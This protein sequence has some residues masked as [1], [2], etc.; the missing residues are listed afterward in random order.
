MPKFN[1]AAN[2]FYILNVAQICMY[3]YMK[4]F[5]NLKE[6]SVLLQNAELLPTGF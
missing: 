4:I 3:S 5:A 1:I 2:T 6:A